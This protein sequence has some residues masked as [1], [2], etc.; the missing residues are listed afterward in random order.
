MSNSAGNSFGTTKVVYERASFL[1][2]LN[3]TRNRFTDV[4]LVCEDA[5]ALPAKSVYIDSHKVVLASASGYFN[6]HDCF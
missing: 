1:R 3:Y 5:T 4:T 6:R 2:Q